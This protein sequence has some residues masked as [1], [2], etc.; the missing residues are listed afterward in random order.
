MQQ[1]DFFAKQPNTNSRDGGETLWVKAVDMR[2]TPMA[3]VAFTTAVEFEERAA[4]ALTTAGLAEQTNTKRGD[5]TVDK[6]YNNPSLSFNYIFM[7]SN[8]TSF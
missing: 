1:Y 6:N 8:Q 7:S 5:I 4:I 3:S 2:D